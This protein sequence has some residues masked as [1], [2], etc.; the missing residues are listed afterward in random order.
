MKMLKCSFCG[1]TKVAEW[2]HPE[3]NQFW[4]LSGYSIN[5]HKMYGT[6]CSEC[7]DLICKPRKHPVSPE[8]LVK[9]KMLGLLR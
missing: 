7:Y 5:S 4:H 6:W 8:T 3:Y 9:A 2:N 1:E